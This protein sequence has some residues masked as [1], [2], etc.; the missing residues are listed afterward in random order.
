MLNM[1]KEEGLGQDGTRIQIPS[2]RQ[3]RISPALGYKSASDAKDSKRTVA[4]SE[5]VRKQDSS[6]I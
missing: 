5:L 2:P 4:I 3:P 6:Y 1:S